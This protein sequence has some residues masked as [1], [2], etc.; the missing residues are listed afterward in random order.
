MFVYIDGIIDNAILHDV[1]A[2]IHFGFRFFFCFLFLVLFISSCF[3]VTLYKVNSPPLQSAIKWMRYSTFIWDIIS[4]NKCRFFLTRI[5]HNFD[6]W[7][8]W[9]LLSLSLSFFSSDMYSLQSREPTRGNRVNR[10][11]KWKEWE[12]WGRALKLGLGLARLLQLAKIR[13]SHIYL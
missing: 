2:T 9:F 4:Y 7:L 12:C 6:N 1:V 8:S 5:K 3:T 11:G 13:L 10:F